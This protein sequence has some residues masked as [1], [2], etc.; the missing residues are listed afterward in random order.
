MLKEENKPIA[1]ESLE[2]TD[3]FTTN[4]IP[5]A[6]FA[7][8]INAWVCVCARNHTDEF[9][10]HFDNKNFAQHSALI[11]SLQYVVSVH[12]LLRVFSYR[13][14]NQLVQITFFYK[15]Y[16]RIYCSHWRKLFNLYNV[17]F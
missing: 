11:E 13:F 17:I 5:Y 10:V 4:I 9:G 6:L 2:I 3:H 8:Y 7:S 1:F 14:S 12:A 15:R 16:L